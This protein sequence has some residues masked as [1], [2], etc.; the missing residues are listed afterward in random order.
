MTRS[1]NLRT[2]ARYTAGGAIAVVVLV[3]IGG[4]IAFGWMP[5]TAPAPAVSVAPVAADAVLTCPGPLLALARDARSASGISVASGE[6]VTASGALRRDVLATTGVPGESGPTRLEAPATGRT[7]PAA[8]GAAS[9]AVIAE[10]LTGF[11]AAACTPALMESWLVGGS[12]STGAADL[13]LL[14]NP[15]K[16]TATVDLTFYGV[17]GPRHPG[18]GSRIIIAPGTQ[19]VLPLAGLGLGDQAPI[20]RVTATGAPVRAALQSSIVRGLTPGGVDQEGAIAAAATTQ[21]VPGVRVTA[22]PTD[23]APAV[24]RLLAPTGA[25]TATVTVLGAS[26]AVGSAM[27]VPLKTG[28]PVEAGLPTL[29]PGSYTVLVT[30]DQ[31][32]VAAV[33]QTTGTGAG[34]DFAWNPAAPPLAATADGSLFAV[35]AG[36]SPSLVV[37]PAGKAAVTASVMPAAG[38]TTTTVSAAAGRAT[39]VPL[40]AGGAY[41]IALDGAAYAAVTFAGDGALASYPVWPQDAASAPVVV[42]P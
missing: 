40:T 5:R 17:D 28:A 2:A 9:A 10:D 18:A 3:V 42:Y 20:L 31:P 26:G 32:V 39:V 34:D 30:A 21:V 8:A 4:G 29:A 35:P 6:D 41:R 23:N 33:W 36:P 1:A 16:V 15:G 11:A 12:T 25:T 37:T 27:T 13:V 22:A 38:G 24:V 14:A 7:V 19:R